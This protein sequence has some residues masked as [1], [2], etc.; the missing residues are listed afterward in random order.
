M[1]ADHTKKIFAEALQTLLSQRSLDKISVLEICDEC[2][3]SKKTFYYHFK[4]KYDLAVYY[5]NSIATKNLSGFGIDDYL[6]ELANGNPVVCDIDDRTPMV[7]LQI[8]EMW[9]KTINPMVGKN[10]LIYSTDKNSPYNVRRTAS[11]AGRKKILKE[12]LDAENKY[13][14]ELQMDI[15]AE[16]MC[17]ISDYFYDRWVYPVDRDAVVS[18]AKQLTE[19]T[20][21]LVTFFVSRAKPRSDK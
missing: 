2:G 4:D 12:R 10:L 1:K 8:I 16:A 17:T 19:V 18:E 21:D 14:D 15:A 3:L 11:L 6:T 5:Y 20:K 9:H 7:M 13:L